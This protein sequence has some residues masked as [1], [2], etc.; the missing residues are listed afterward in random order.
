MPDTANP[1]AALSLGARLRAARER[2]GYDKQQAAEKLHCDPSIIDALEGDR[3]ELLGAPVYVRG[4]VR[5]YAE[6]VADSPGEVQELCAQ[7]TSQSTATPDLTRIPKGE[8]PAEPSSLVR[9]LVGVG[10]VLLIAA[11]TWFVLKGQAPRGLAD[12]VPLGDATSSEQPAAPGPS[13]AGAAATGAVATGA[14]EPGG[15]PAVVGQEH[16]LAPAAGGASASGTAPAT[17][18]PGT[19]APNGPASSLASNPA[20]AGPASG[21]SGGTQLRVTADMDCW[22]EAYDASGKRIYFGMAS[23]RSV[24][25]ITGTAPLRV[26]LGNVRSVKFEVD[27]KPTTIPESVRRGTSAWFAVSADGQIRPSAD[28]PASGA[29]SDTRKPQATAK[30]GAASRAAAKPRPKRP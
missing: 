3:F 13:V 24:Q 22:I 30:P 4:H 5:R 12:V 26:L 28:L 1:T 17:T 25:Q 9:P 16:N 18:A 27:G 11:G 20:S 29:V 7:L 6:L 2:A 19:A 15:I 14:T 10:I 23:P 21:T 8:R